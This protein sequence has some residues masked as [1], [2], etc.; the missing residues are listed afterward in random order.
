MP[1]LNKIITKDPDLGRVQ[2]AIKVAYDGLVNVPFTQTQLIDVAFSA[3]GTDKTVPHSLGR[4]PQGFI[5]VDKNAAS[6]IYRTQWNASS[7]V[8]RAS[9]IANVRI[10][11]F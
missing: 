3:G 4:V 8:L 6:D 7:I 2:D 11:L 5:V 1:V 9:A 10:M